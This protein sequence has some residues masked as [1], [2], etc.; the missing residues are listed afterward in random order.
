M[1]GSNELCNFVVIDSTLVKASEMFKFN[2]NSNTNIRE[3]FLC[4]QS[5]TS[6]CLSADFTLVI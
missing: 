3:S 2:I 4:Q 1:R 6:A 5:P